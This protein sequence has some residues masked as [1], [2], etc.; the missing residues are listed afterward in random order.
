NGSLT[1]T[2][3]DRGKGIAP[4]DLGRVFDPFFTS[5]STGTGIGLSIV[6]RF[7]EAAHGSVSLERREGGGMAARITLPEYGG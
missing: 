1:I 7:V 4:A 2:I 5:K 6:K 3:F